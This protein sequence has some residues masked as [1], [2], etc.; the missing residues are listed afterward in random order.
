MHCGSDYR[1]DILVVAVRL[2]FEAPSI[3]SIQ[4]SYSPADS[5]KPTD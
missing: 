2:L 1:M 3:A 5:A 4:I